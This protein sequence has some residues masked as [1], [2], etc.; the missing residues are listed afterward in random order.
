MK[1]SLGRGLSALLGEEALSEKE[2]A[3]QKGTRSVAIDQIH[4]GRL[5][6][7]QNFDDD[8]MKSL[9]DSVIAQGILQPLLVRPHPE[10]AGAFEILAG[11][12]RWRAAQKARLHEVP[13]VVREIGDREALEIALV[14]NVQR[15]DLN[16]IEEAQGYKRLIDEFAHTQEELAKALGK[17]RSHIANLLRLINLPVEVKAMLA[18]GRLSMGHARAILA[19]DDPLDLA[20]R[21]VAEDLSVRQTERAAKPEAVEFETHPHGKHKRKRKADANV[22]AL[23]RELSHALG[24]QVKITFD[25]KGGHLSIRYKSLDQLDG[26]L[27]K[28]RHRH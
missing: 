3:P 20:R 12:R 19:S 8:A 21:V 7:R 4:P 16:P 22:A 18:A 26:V 24:L 23:E 27:K 6:P 11:E 17:S 10:F 9:V 1:R 25:G 15:S 13:V 5:Q 28:L 14:E 2:S